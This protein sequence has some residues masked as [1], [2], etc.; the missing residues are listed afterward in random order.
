MS[1]RSLH[2]PSHIMA[3]TYPRQP[4]EGNVVTQLY[5]SSSV[6][7][8]DLICEMSWMWRDQFKLHYTMVL[9]NFWCFLGNM[10]STQLEPWH[11]F[12]MCSRHLLE[13]SKLGV[14]CKEYCQSKLLVT[15]VFLNTHITV[16]IIPTAGI[17]FSV[18]NHQSL[19]CI[20]LSIQLIRASA[21]YTSDTGMITG[22]ERLARNKHPHLKISL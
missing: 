14:D 5:Q 9:G 22:M 1:E 21:K 10:D 7:F 18:S 6:E 12:A 8:Q 17:L 2:Q 16:A 20:L 3:E 11:P 4:K 19:I 13:N 15:W